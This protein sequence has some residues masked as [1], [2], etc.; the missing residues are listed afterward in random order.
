VTQALVARGLSAKE[1]AESV[2]ALVDGK[3]GGNEKTAQGAGNNVGAL[4]QARDAALAFGRTKL[5]L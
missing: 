4:A 3:S 1:W 5:G 2:A